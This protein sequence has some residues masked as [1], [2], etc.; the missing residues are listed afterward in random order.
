MRSF[1]VCT[2]TV[3]LFSNGYASSSAPATAGKLA[4]HFDITRCLKCHEEIAKEYETSAHAVSTGNPRFL[5]AFREISGKEPD[6]ISAGNKKKVQKACL[7]CHVPQIDTA[8]DGLT[9]YISSLIIKSSLNDTSAQ[10]ELAELTVNCRVCHMMQGM[11]QGKVQPM[12]IYGPGWD[13]DDESHKEEYGFDTLTSDYLQS[14]DFCIVCH[15]SCPPDLPESMCSSL[16]AR[17]ERHYN[18]LRYRQPCQK[19]HMQEKGSVTHSFPVK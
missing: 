19:C 11:P 5:R 16:H 9:N 3:F 14:S 18:V 17:A 4:A 12:T 13:E 10:N 8:S 15:D 7:S 1:I 6:T 2:I